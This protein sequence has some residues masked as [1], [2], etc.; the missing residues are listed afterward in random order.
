MERFRRGETVNCDEWEFWT[1]LPGASFRLALRIL[2][3]GA[4]ELAIE[5]MGS[6]VDAPGVC[7][8]QNAPVSW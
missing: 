5:R 7:V 3:L 8:A 2:V 4:R 1:S 6:G